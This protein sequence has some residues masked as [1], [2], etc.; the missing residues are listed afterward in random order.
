MLALS[1]LADSAVE[2]YRG[3]FQ[4]RAMYTPLVAAAL[5]LGAACLALADTRAARHACATRSMRSAAATGLAGTG[6]HLYN[7][8]KRPGGLSWLNLFYAA[9]LG[10]PMALALAGLLGRGAE[11]VRDTPPDATPRIFGLPAGRMLAAVAAAGLL[12][13]VGEAGLLHFRGAYHDPSC[14]CR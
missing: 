10:A 1:V 3:S 6:F 5:T 2:H 12:G 8:A 14:S 11:R 13:T 9:P 4:N 7:I